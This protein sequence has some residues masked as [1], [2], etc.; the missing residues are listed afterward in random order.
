MAGLLHVR[1]GA[2]GL[3]GSHPGEGLGGL[4]QEVAQTA[5]QHRVAPG[6]R[7]GVILHAHALKILDGHAVLLPLIAQWVPYGLEAEAIESLEEIAAHCFAREA[8]VLASG[9]GARAVEDVRLAPQR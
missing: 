1:P 4:A 2:G 7:L 9:R 6:Y 3:E 8:E 5:Y